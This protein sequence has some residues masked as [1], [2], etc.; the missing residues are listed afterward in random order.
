MPATIIL[1]VL[2]ALATSGIIL[3]ADAGWVV[4]LLVYS[5][6]GMSVTMI[7]ALRSAWIARSHMQA[8]VQSPQS[9]HSK[10]LKAKQ[11]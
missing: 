8:Q 9:P 5:L 2:V 4:V 11:H 7:F 6:T 3:S 10:G 1:A